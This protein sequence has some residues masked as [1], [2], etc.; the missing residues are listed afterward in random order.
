MKYDM[1]WLIDTLKRG[2]KMLA[3]LR[4]DTPSGK[5]HAIRAA[6]CQVDAA[7]LIAESIQKGEEVFE[8]AK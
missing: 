5:C 8:K 3:K 4:D 1:D 2:R 6:I 7:V